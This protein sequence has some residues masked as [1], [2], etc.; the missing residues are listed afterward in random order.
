MNDSV[1][2]QKLIEILIQKNYFSTNKYNPKIVID[3]ASSVGIADSHLINIINQLVNSGDLVFQYDPDPQLHPMDKLDFWRI[4]LTEKGR[5]YFCKNNPLEKLH[6]TIKFNKNSADFLN[7][8]LSLLEK[9]EAEYSL[10]L[11]L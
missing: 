9:R 7:E 11:G 10:M 6:V 8:T 5:Q 1:K 2:L 4:D 3:A